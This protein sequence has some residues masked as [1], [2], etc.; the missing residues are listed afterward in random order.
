M[1]FSLF[2]LLAGLAADP[3]DVVLV[4]GKLGLAQMNQLD[5]LK[6]PSP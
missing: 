4:D 6:A 2:F 5:E 3:G 1:R